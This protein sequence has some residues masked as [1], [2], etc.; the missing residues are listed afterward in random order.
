MRLPTARHASNED[1][2]P[3]WALCSTRSL[4]E[5]QDVCQRHL[6]GVIY[7][8]IY[9]LQNAVVLSEIKTAHSH[10]VPSAMHPGTILAPMQ[11]QDNSCAGTYVRPCLGVCLDGG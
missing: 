7:V 6:R 11:S 3:L 2:D 10:N 9:S 5:L 1:G 8:R 4:Y